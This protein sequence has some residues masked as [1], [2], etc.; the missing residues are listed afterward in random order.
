MYTSLASVTLNW[1]IAPDSSSLVSFDPIK[2]RAPNAVTC[3]QLHTN[4]PVRSV[5]E[6]GDHEKQQ[7]EEEVHEN[8]K[9][10]AWH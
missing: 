4:V 5:V 2:Y 3:M 7:Q 10:K 1:W 9:K 6:N 8:R